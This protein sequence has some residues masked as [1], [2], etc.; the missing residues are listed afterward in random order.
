MTTPNKAENAAAADLKPD[1]KRMREQARK[2]VSSGAITP[3]YGADP[4]K[5]CE[6][7]NEALA[8]EL[9]CALRYK[10]HYFMATGMASD[11]VKAEFKEHA[12]QEQEHADKLA[13]RITQL[14]GEPDFN[15]ATIA[16]RS[17]AEY[18]EGSGLREMIY[19]DLVAER[20]AIQSYTEMLKQLEN[21]DPT[22]YHV[23]REILS[24]EEEHAEDMVS[25][26][27][28]LP[29]AEPH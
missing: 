12:E 26:L 19:E 14:G 6:M 11:S 18:V 16:A 15:P 27:Q 4:E 2:E 3:S 7:L 20:I 17:H 25:L 10:R 29:A 9:L 13:E 5:V 8:T 28:G 1:V 22:T 23:V 24:V 21:K